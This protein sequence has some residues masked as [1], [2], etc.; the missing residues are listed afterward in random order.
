M[1]AVTDLGIIIP[2]A[3]DMGTQ[4]N[5]VCPPDR[6]MCHPMAAICVGCIQSMQTCQPGFTCDDTN[7]CVP[8][9]PA[10]PC[11]RNVDCPLRLDGFD[12]SKIKCDTSTGMCEECLANEDCTSVSGDIGTCLPNKRCLQPDM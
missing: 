2:C 1:S 9:N 12:Q 8:I 5:P 4:T 3:I 10:A 11:K 6:P 7:T